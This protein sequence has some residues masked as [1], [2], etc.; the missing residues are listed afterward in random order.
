MLARSASSWHGD[1]TWTGGGAYCPI[2]YCSVGTTVSIR[3]MTTVP[4]YS[5]V[6]SMLGSGSRRYCTYQQW[7]VG[8]S[9]ALFGLYHSHCLQADLSSNY[10]VQ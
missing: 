10:T 3:F 7:S 1:V 8:V 2:V 5:A 4:R 6:R 9:P